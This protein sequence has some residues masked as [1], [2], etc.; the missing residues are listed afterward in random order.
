ML[1]FNQ[2]LRTR[3][4]YQSDSDAIPVA[5]VEGITSAPFCRAAA[6]PHRRRRAGDESRR[7]DVGR[8]HAARVR[9][10][11][12]DVPRRRAVADAAAVAAAAAAAAPARPAQRDRLAELEPAARAGARL[13]EAGPKPARWTGTSSRSCRSLEARQA[14]FVAAG[15]ETGDPRRGG[16]GRES[17]RPHRARIGPGR[18]SASPRLLKEH[19]VPVILSSHPDA[20]AARGSL[21]RLHV[22]DARRAR[23]GR[24]ARSRSRAAATSRAQRSVPGR[25]CRRVGPRPRR[26]DPGAHD[27]RR[28][29]SRRRQARSAARAGKLANLIVVSG[30]PLEIRSRDS[31][32][33][34]RRPRRAARQ[35]AHRAVQALHG[36]AVGEGRR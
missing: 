15:T 27:R 33:R 35:Q 12:D 5:R 11:R 21:P 16:V 32:R 13:R 2:M 36:A 18:R 7:L 14:L 30:D 34:H 3:V 19:N 1:T 6:S 31:A 8:E 20:A 10:P 17:R 25:P 26:G 22:P 28:E 29:D 24:R 23:E 4:A 9:R